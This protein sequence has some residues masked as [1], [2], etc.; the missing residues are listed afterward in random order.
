VLDAA[1]RETADVAERRASACGQR[2]GDQ[3]FF[4]ISTIACIAAM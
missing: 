3:V 1:R 4:P 2:P